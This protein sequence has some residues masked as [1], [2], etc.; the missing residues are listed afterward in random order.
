[1]A[2]SED[3]DKAN[4]FRDA[5]NF[6]KAEQ[7]VPDEVKKLGSFKEV[8]KATGLTKFSDF[9]ESE[10]VVEN[11]DDILR[12][13]NRDPKKYYVVGSSVKFRQWT[14]ADGSTANHIM[15][16][17]ASKDPNVNDE[18]LKSSKDAL[19]NWKPVRF[20]AKAKGDSSFVV[21]LSDWQLGKNERGG[22]EQ[23]IKR[24]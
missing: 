12:H 20:N 19:K 10:D 9:I 15:C 1:M 24:I 11:F 17:I 22:T 6:K 16:D 5:L 7:A 21:I 8:D 14:A 3:K 13:F 23:L 18:I 4:K 2:S